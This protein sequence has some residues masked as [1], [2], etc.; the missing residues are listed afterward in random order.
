MR[1]MKNIVDISRKLNE[2]I[3]KSLRNILKRFDKSMNL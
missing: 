2:Q 1:V 3:W